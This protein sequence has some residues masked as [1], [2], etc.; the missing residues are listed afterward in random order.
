MCQVLF[1]EM[2]WIGT[3]EANPSEAPLEMPAEL[4]EAIEHAPAAGEPPLLP[5]DLYHP[6]DCLSGLP[7]Q[8]ES[9]E[10]YRT[11]RSGASLSPLAQSYAPLPPSERKA[12]GVIVALHARR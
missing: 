4:Q 6:L 9:T 8:Q 3:A 1:A 5:S 11:G 7:D 12:S 10:L 2:H